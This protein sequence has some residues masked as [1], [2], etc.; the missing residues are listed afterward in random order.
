SALEER[1]APW[2]LDRSIERRAPRTPN[3]LSAS[4]PAVLEQGL[5]LYRAQCAVCHGAPGVEIGE[6]G[7]GL[8]PVPPLLDARAVQAR[9]DGELFW[10]VKNGIRLTGMPGWG[11][12]HA[13]RDLWALVAFVRRLPKLTDAERARLSPLRQTP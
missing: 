11:G 7:R 1:F 10:I 3:P 2:A 6:A 8:N 9:T 5:A 12:T 13:D 4:D